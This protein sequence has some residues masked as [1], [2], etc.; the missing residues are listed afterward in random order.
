[1]L[2]GHG[3]EDNRADTLDLYDGGVPKLDEATH[4]GVQV[5]EVLPSPGLVV[6]GVVSMYLPRSCHC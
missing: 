5:G 1:M 2:A 6:G 3:G 4:T